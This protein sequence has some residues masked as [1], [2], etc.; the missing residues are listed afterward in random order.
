MTFDPVHVIERG[1]EPASD[2]LEWLERLAQE[3]IPHIDGGWISGAA[4]FAEFPGPPAHV[5]AVSRDGS[6]VDVRANLKMVRGAHLSVTPDQMRETIRFLR[7][8][9]IV[10]IVDLLGKL[11]AGITESAP[12]LAADSL[13]VLVNDGAGE[14]AVFSNVNAKR[15]AVDDA[16]RRM[17]QRVAIHLGAGRRLLGRLPSADASD[18]EAVLD[19]GGALEHAVGI[20]TQSSTR[21]A[22]RSAVKCM[23][24]ARTRSGRR[25][26]LHALDLWRGLL[27]GRWTLVDHF[28]SDGRRFVLARKNDP[29]VGEP[30]ALSRRQR[31]VA[32]YASLGWSNQEIGYAL[33]LSE[34]TV[35]AHLR[36]SL[37][38]L[39]VA[40]RAGLVRWANEI[41]L[42]GDRRPTTSKGSRDRGA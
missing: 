22:L 37:K 10:S 28:D 1:Y 26:P 25:A 33:G 42:A 19:P 27:A 31:Q 39:Q 16:A 14:I 2:R 6:P 13:A 3:V 5:V 24:Q 34:N 8:P 15:V 30:R 40:T 7:T 41:A 21:D 29:D 20:A 11:P 12:T 32:F 23:D 18:V 9:G 36:L 4:Y 38:K 35:S 17:W